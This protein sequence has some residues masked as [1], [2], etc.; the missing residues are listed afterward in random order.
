MSSTEWIKVLFTPNLRKEMGN[1][2]DQELEKLL[3][4]EA[5]GT[6][7]AVCGAEIGSVSSPLIIN[8]VPEKGTPK[9]GKWVV[10]FVKSRGEGEFVPQAFCPRHLMTGRRV[11]R[12]KFLPAQSREEALKRASDLNAR[13]TWRR[14]IFGEPSPPLKEDLGSIL[15]RQPLPVVP[16]PPKRRR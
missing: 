12:G 13:R 8:G 16:P 14:S 5:D 3:V 10:V 4:V 7:C 9:R 1:P 6:K 2:T 11:V 15:K